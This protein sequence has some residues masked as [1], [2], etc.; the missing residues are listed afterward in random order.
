MNPTRRMNQGLIDVTRRIPHRLRRR[1]AWLAFAALL[2]AAVPMGARAFQR[3][4]GN[5]FWASSFY[6][7]SVNTTSISAGG[8]IP[9]LGLTADQVHWWTAWASSQWSDASGGRVL[10]SDLGSTPFTPMSCGGAAN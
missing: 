7:Y 5:P 1:I 9:G 6:K 2:P 8:S 10:L 4:P 3:A